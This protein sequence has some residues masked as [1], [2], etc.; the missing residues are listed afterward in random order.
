M[1]YDF[2]T[3]QAVAGMDMTDIKNPAFRKLK[4]G[5]LF[6]KFYIIPQKVSRGKQDK[7]HDD[8]DMRLETRDEIASGNGAGRET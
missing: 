8:G 7:R 5:F 6:S 4:T 3:A 2:G 1:S